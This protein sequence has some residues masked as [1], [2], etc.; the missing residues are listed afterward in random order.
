MSRYLVQSPKTTRN[1]P[2]NRASPNNS[3]KKTRNVASERKRKKEQEIQQERKSVKQL[4]GFWT[5]WAKTRKEMQENS[6]LRVNAPVAPGAAR[7]DTS[8]TLSNRQNSQR[9]NCDVTTAGQKITTGQIGFTSNAL[10]SEIT[11]SI[12]N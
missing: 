8:S 9:Q 2:E 7:D 10:K 3:K 5:N 11:T 6:Q 4:K 1:K 12:Q